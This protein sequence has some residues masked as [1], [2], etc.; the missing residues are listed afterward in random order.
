MPLSE[1]SKLVVPALN[2]QPAGIYALKD[3]YARQLLSGGIEHRV[4]WNGL[5]TPV[6]ANIPDCVSIRYND[7][8]YTGTLSA[9]NGQP[10]VFYL[11]KNTEGGSDNFAEY[12]VATDAATNTKYWE[13]LGYQGLDL[14]NLG[15]LAYM[16]SVDLNK[17]NG[18]N[19]I[20]ANATLQ[21]SSS[22]VNFGTHSTQTVLG[23]TTTFTPVD[24]VYELR[25]SKGSI[26]LSR[27]TDAA[28]NTTSSTAVTA[29]DTEL[30]HKEP[31]IK[32]DSNA[33]KRRKILTTQIRGVTGSSVP[34]SVTITPVTHRLI[35]D[36]FTPVAVTT[37]SLSGYVT[38]NKKYLGTT[39]VTGVTGSVTASNISN[40]TVRSLDT[41]TFYK[42]SP[43]TANNSNNNEWKDTVANLDIH[44]YSTQ[45]DPTTGIFA[46]ADNET[47]VISYKTIPSV[48]VASTETTFATGEDNMGDNVSFVKDFTIG[49]VTVPVANDTATTVAT[50]SLTDSTAG[51]QVVYS[52]SYPTNLPIPE[53][54]R[55]ITYA[56]GAVSN[57]AT[58]DNSESGGYVV[59]NVPNGSV[60][61]PE[62]DNE[63]QT[64]LKNDT[65]NA[66][67]ASSDINVLTE[68][69]L[70]GNTAQAYT[71]IAFESD[72]FLKSASISAQPAF[73][74]SVTSD[75]NG[76]VLMNASVYKTANG[77][78]NVG[79]NDPVEAIVGLGEGT[80]AAQ[81]ISFV[82]KN[83]KKVP[84]YD[85]LKIEAESHPATR[86]LNF[87]TPTG[88]T[89]SLVKTG[90]PTVV[91][92]ETSLDGVNWTLWEA[93]NNGNR[94]KTVAAGE[95]LYV[96]N[97][98]VTSTGFSLLDGSSIEV[99]YYTFNVPD[100]TEVN[101]ILESLLCRTPEFGKVASGGFQRLFAQ[102]NIKGKP[103]IASN[104]LPAG[105]CYRLFYNTTN[106]SALNSVEIRATGTPGTNA[107]STWLRGCASTGTVYCPETLELS[108]GTDS[109][110]PS[111][112]TRVNI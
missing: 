53:A 41:D 11:V 12:V 70:T 75:D 83:L 21:A 100:E 42:V 17:G 10:M 79:S 95:R 105:S 46:E 110:I 31:F 84:L 9:Q 45:T 82:D 76:D 14:S 58:T 35:T 38:A 104:A 69:Q 97:K 29:L 77:S 98:S 92:L 3:T 7:T 86:Y 37:T 48:K 28:L 19:V 67:M 89:I 18:Y 101:G 107:T 71:N 91:E 33:F 61:V 44:M 40:K 81:D 63:A 109:G 62:I 6:V 68:V 55:E 1:I 36:T 106:G 25:R 99:H 85:D 64:V 26:S 56:T 47:L 51:D 60:N 2:G 59:T 65:T 24:P 80:A 30:S 111:N 4:V 49:N 34:A 54:G 32:A 16:D 43:I 94:S 13:Q 27:T 103:I 88:G 23:A 108:S 112:W 57:S 78:I 66:T 102:Q 90:E 74:A 50:G 96:R 93:D 20:G 52:I 73:S 72:S 22:T 87:V 5:S 8:V 39:T 15:A